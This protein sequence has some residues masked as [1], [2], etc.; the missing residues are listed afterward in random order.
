MSASGGAES[1]LTIDIKPPYD[2]AAV[3][4][5]LAPELRERVTVREV[6]YSREEAA[7]FHSQFDAALRQI[8]MP[9][10]VASFSHERDRF[11]ITVTSEADAARLRAVMPEGLKAAS[12]IH[13]QPSPL[14]VLTSG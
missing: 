1:Q 9:E 2:R 13:V 4:A 5:A 3:M 6:R 10:A 8:G 12:E 7:A 11:E 14:V